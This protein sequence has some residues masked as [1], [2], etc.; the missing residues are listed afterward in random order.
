MGCFVGSTYSKLCG[1]M[2]YWKT[3][4]RHIVN[5]FRVGLPFIIR[6]FGGYCLGENNEACNEYMGHSHEVVARENSS[7]NENESRNNHI[8]GKR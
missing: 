8:V 3:Y 7:Y 1:Y 6:F 2:P 5:T 4:F